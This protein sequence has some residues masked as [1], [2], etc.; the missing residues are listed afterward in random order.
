ML[1]VLVFVSLVLAI[2]AILYG[3]K[4]KQRAIGVMVVVA[5]VVYVL[6][7]WYCV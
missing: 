3:E 4:T 6:K 2:I 1:H 5:T 7:R